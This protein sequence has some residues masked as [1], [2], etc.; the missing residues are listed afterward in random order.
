MQNL[1]LV[2]ETVF[3]EFKGGV[4]RWFLELSSELVKSGTKVKYLN[5][6]Y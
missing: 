3:P 4:E 2:Y 1:A 5:Y 6:S